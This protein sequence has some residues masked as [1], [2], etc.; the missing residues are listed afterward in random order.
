MN[1]IANVSDL[2]DAFVTEREGTGHWR[3]AAREHEVEIA[4]RHGERFD[5]RFSRTLQRRRS[6]FAPFD[7]SCL[8]ER[9]LLHA[10]MIV[11]SVASLQPVSPFAVRWLL[12]RLAL[13]SIAM[14]PLKAHVHNG[15]LVLDEPTDLPEG[16]IVYL[17]PVDAD[18]LDDDERG[19]LHEAIHESVEQMKAGETID[20]AE[21]LA[22][23]RAHR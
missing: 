1:V 2:G 6:S 4:T 10:A 13:E 11:D 22:E 18:E 7:F 19:R 14:T 12:N 17:L 5:E 3:L 9:E 8:D 20:A 15:R 16:E 23:L 21:A